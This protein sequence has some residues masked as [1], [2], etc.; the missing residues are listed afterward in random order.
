MVKQID[1]HGSDVHCCHTSYPGLETIYHFKR[2]AVVNAGGGISFFVIAHGWI[3][4][5]NHVEKITIWGGYLIEVKTPEWWDERV[6][7]EE[8]T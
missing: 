1:P 8:K 4:K 3:S 6:D 7:Q 5:D 2:D